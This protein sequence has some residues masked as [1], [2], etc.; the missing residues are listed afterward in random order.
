ML[1]AEAVTTRI[2]TG[3]SPLSPVVTAVDWWSERDRRR[4]Q[5][6]KSRPSDPLRGKGWQSAT[7]I[8]REALVL[9]A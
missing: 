8:E 2:N 4:T 7:R 1:S 9:F 5:C 6:T 3:V